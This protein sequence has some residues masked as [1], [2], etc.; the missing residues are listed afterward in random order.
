MSKKIG[1]LY[2]W[3]VG[4]WRENKFIVPANLYSLKFF[5][6]DAFLFL[7]EICKKT[8]KEFILQSN[9][10]RNS[11]YNDGHLVIVNSE[12]EDCVTNDNRKATKFNFE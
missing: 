3:C 9:D 1:F 8:G 2:T 5:T 7:N 4:Y 11:L 6:D 12:C 10:T